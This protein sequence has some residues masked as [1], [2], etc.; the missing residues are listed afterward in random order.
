MPA[1]I[2]EETSHS[3]LSPSSSSR[4]MRCPSSIPLSR[5]I[6]DTQ[7]NAA[8]RRGTAIHAVGEQM[9]KGIKKEIGGSILDGE[10]HSYIDAEM[11]REAEQYANYVRAL[12]TEPDAE[13]FIE[14]KVD[15]F[16]EYDLSGHVDA[17][18]INGTTLS[19]CDLKSGRVPVKAEENSQL[20]LYA[21]GLYEE[22]SMFYDIDTIALHIIQDNPSISNTNSWECSVDDLMDFKEFAKNK[23]EEALSDNPTPVP[24]EVQCKYCRAASVCPALI[25]EVTEAFEKLEEVDTKMSEPDTAADV[26]DVTIAE[27]LSKKKLIEVAFKAFEDRLYN[28]MI[29]GKDVPGFKLVQKQTRKRWIDETDAYTKLKSWAPIDEVAP[30][31]L[32]TPTQAAKLM[33]KMSTKKSNIFNGLW[34][35]PEGEVIL[36]P[37]SDRRA[38]VNPVQAFDDLDVEEDAEL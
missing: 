3:E 21:I 28:D 12:L 19:V 20:M 31:K 30:R 6:P 13:L 10:G 5:N 7:T 36:V 34:E 18:V 22:H 23:A 2:V 15:I 17:C 1:V 16:P 37:E 4:W 24:G 11:F 27:L 9:L 38:P 35:K 8:A 33:G 29:N 25:E 26:L 14:E 32:V